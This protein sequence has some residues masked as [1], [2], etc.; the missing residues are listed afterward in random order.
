MRFGLGAWLA[1]VALGCGGPGGLG[2]A[3]SPFGKQV[4]AVRDKRADRIEAE[5]PPT[6]AEWESLRGLAG[7]RVVVLQRGVAGDT[8]AAILATLHPQPR[9]HS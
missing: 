2:D 6:A 4:L 7:L 9:M 5:A 8:E 1:V 3:S